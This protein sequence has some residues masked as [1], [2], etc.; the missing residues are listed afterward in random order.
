MP[1]LSLDS[2]SG[3]TVSTQTAL[4]SLVA[5]L[6]LFCLVIHETLAPAHVHFL[7]LRKKWRLPRALQVSL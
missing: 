4:L 6:Y 2:L 1:F 5:F 7:P 3:A